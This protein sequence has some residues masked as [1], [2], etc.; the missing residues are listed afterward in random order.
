M[1]GLNLPIQTDAN[2]EHLTAGEDDTFHFLFTDLSISE[3]WYDD[4]LNY[5][6]CF[7]ILIWIILIMLDFQPMMLCWGKQRPGSWVI[8]IKNLK[9]VSTLAPKLFLWWTLPVNIII[10]V[11]C[12]VVLILCFLERDQSFQSVFYNLPF[13][14]QGF[15]IVNEQIQHPCSYVRRL[16][17]FTSDHLAVTNLAPKMQKGYARP[18]LHTVPSVIIQVLIVHMGMLVG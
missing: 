16:V 13:S 9:A 5:S 11:I 6:N 12:W 7:V 15:M 4:Y 17:L 1:N 2:S 8:I 14:N 3:I 10:L 18:Y